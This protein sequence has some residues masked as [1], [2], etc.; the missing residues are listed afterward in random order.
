MYIKYYYL[1]TSERSWSTGC[2]GRPVPGRPG[3]IQ[4]GYRSNTVTV[5][6]HQR[7]LSTWTPRL[8]HKHK[9]YQPAWPFASPQRLPHYAIWNN[10]NN[11]HPKA[12]SLALKHA[13]KPTL[14]WRMT[15]VF[16]AGGKSQ[17]RRIKTKRPPSAAGKTPGSW[18]DG[19]RRGSQAAVLKTR[20][21]A[22][23]E[24]SMTQYFR[25]GFAAL[26]Q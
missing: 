7:K 13:Q 4:L 23:R 17:D 8:V 9:R 16:T 24:P 22:S 18:K 19:G 20:I 12:L 25:A 15:S 10:N 1:G 21:L 5:L 2:E 26:F 14:T 6:P 11:K 3:G